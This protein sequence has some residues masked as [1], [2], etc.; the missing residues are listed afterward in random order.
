[1]NI[2]ALIAFVVLIAIGIF[3]YSYY[4]S[5][6][7]EER[8]AAIKAETDRVQ[9]E[10]ARLEAEQKETKQQRIASQA[11]L[12]QGMQTASTTA[13]SASMVAS[14][15][16]EVKLANYEEVD[17]AKLQ[18]IKARWEST[19]TLANSTARIA[20]APIV[21]DLQA[22]RQELEKLNVTK[23]LTPAKD[24]LLTAMKINE[25]GF[26]AFMSDADLGKLVAQIK[27]EDVQK[28]I[29]DY[30]RISSMCN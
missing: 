15:E 23:C 1:M 29:D 26:L 12:N 14:K 13:T 8:L 2:K 17:K 28:N 9:A 6:K 4:S 7:H 19:R 5:K 22:E 16:V 24:K 10:A 20:L 21:R 18:D 27:V 30:T 11:P 3:G 25:E